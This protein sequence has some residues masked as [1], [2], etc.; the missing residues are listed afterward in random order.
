M[1]DKLLAGQNGFIWWFGVVENNR[2]DMGLGRVQVRIVGH[3]NQDINELPTEALPWSMV[4]LPTDNPV[5]GG[6]GE[7]NSL[8]NGCR[9]FGFFADGDSRNTPIVL[10]VISGEH[11]GV[12]TQNVPS[13]ATP[14]FPDLFNIQEETECPSGNVSDVV[15]V[16]GVPIDSKNI[17]INKS[18]WVYPCVGFVSAAYG[19]RNGR[20]HGVDIC[21]LMTQ[22]EAGNSRLNGK[23]RSGVGSP[24]YAAAAGKVVYKWDKKHGQKGV[25]SN[26]DITGSGSRSFGNAI[27]IRHETST[28]VFTTIYAHLGTNQDAGDDGINS[29]VD[30]QVGETVSKGQKIGTIGTTH[31]FSS[32][33]H[34]HFEVRVGDGLPRANNHINPSIIFPKLYCTHNSFLGW[35]RSQTKYN[36]TVPFTK[37]DMP[38]QAK[39]VPV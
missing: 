25:S 24:V 26:Y 38:I 21:P 9:V 19:E 39:E 27:A 12:I 10:G 2:D 20:H 8:K 31:N 16:N 22:T 11:T 6:V 4:I 14:F 34:L 15:T 30:V 5:I 35:L 3:H 18:E 33:V 29:G 1:T 37:K 23:F 28:G 17:K 32:P 13:G 36:V 7:S